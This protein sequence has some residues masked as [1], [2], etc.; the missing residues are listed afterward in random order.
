MSERGNESI[1]RETGFRIGA[2]GRP[3]GTS[4]TDKGVI[5]Y[6]CNSPNDDVLEKLQILKLGSKFGI[7]SNEVLL[8]P[9]EL[10]EKKGIKEGNRGTVEAEN[11]LRQLS[12]NN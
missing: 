11:L 1:Q 8:I 2:N 4:E 7:Q 9:D 5:H 3:E 6:T 12:K 10:F